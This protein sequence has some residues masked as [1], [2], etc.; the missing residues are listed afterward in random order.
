METVDSF[1]QGLEGI[2]FSN[3]FFDL[4]RLGAT[5]LLCPTRLDKWLIDAVFKLFSLGYGSGK[6]IKN[7]TFRYSELFSTLR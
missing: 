6:A 4:D 7:V 2:I 5:G 3:T 1:S